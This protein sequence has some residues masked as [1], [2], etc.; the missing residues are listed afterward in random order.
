MVWA[1]D[2]LVLWSGS[3]PSSTAGEP[4]SDGA[5]W[6]PATGWQELAPPPDAD[7]LVP[8]GFALWTGREV[9][10]GPV[11]SAATG[12]R[13]Q[14]GDGSTMLAY[15]PASDSW[16]RIVPDGAAAEAL[17]DPTVRFSGVASLVGDE[18]LVGRTGGGT[19]AGRQPGYLVALDPTTGASRVLD[20]GPF[21]AS[22]YLD[23]SGELLVT[24][25]GEKLLAS[26]NWAAEAWLLDPSGS[27]TWTPTSPPPI[28]DLHLHGS[29]WMEDEALF[30]ANDPPVAYEVARDRWRS[31]TAPPPALFWARLDGVDAMRRAG[32][33]ILLVEGM[34]DP[35]ADAWPALPRLPVPEQEVR[36]GAFVDW[37]GDAV[38]VFGGGSY[39][40]PVDATC[41]VDPAQ[42]DWTQEGWTYRP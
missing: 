14:S 9:V 31:L 6:V 7:A 32:D 37:T 22:P 8:G 28:T 35:A 25:A 13:Q 36:I 2:R 30:L 24:V 23:L 27:G 16:R 3:K 19:G 11:A 1:G 15:R 10:L 34:Y 21:D 17:G 38:V 29:V 12:R 18:I 5:M 33:R 40:C 20:P 41:E 42:I 26:P 39:E 4:L